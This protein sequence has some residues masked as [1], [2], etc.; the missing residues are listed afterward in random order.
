MEELTDAI[1]GFLRSENAT[2]PMIA[3]HA[4]TANKRKKEEKWLML[5]MGLLIKE[6][7]MTIINITHLIPMPVENYCY[8]LPALPFPAHTLDIIVVYYHSLHS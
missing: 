6:F 8:Y 4:T 7:N 3:Y 1:M 2:Q 5:L